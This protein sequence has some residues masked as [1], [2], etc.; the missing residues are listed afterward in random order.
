MTERAKKAEAEIEKL[1]REL[2]E[3]RALI[4]EAR[5]ETNET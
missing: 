5:K 3:A 1:C 2:A 4:I